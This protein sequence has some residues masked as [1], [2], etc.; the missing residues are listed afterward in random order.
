MHGHLRDSG[1]PT[2]ISK[3][4]LIAVLIGCWATSAASAAK[5][6]DFASCGDAGYERLYSYDSGSLR[7]KNGVASV[8]VNADYSRV[9]ASKAKRA[10]MTWAIDCA[11]RSFEEK[12]RIEYG[13]KGN[14][15]ARYKSTDQ[16][17]INAGSV[18]EKLA[19]KVCS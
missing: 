9:P 14:T 16:M 7:K 8:L 15:V 13:P 4:C 19:D 10:K 11:G 5:W 17:K 18:A 1:R 6:T 3:T 2:F 12:S